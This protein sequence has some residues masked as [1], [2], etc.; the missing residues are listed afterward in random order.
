MQILEVQSHRSGYGGRVGGRQRCCCSI[1]ALLLATY[2]YEKLWA[3]RLIIVI[4]HVINTRLRNRGVGAQRDFSR[5]LQ[6]YKSRWP[7]FVKVVDCNACS[8]V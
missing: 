8:I 2:D 6:C 1:F 3:W 4:D 5:G 7:L